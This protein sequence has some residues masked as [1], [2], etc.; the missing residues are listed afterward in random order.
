MAHF[1]TPLKDARGL[2][3]AKEGVEHWWVQRVTAVAL[4]PLMVWFV[5]SVIG[6][7][8]ADYLTFVAW[9]AQP[10]P[11][12][13][14]ILTIALT[15]WHGALGMQVVIEDYIHNEGARLAVILLTKFILYGLG[16]ATIFAVLRIAL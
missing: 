3:S 8:G 6:L 9:L 7:I 10:I 13:L 16:V 15:F 5:I 12:V 4:V 1:R 14:M 2:G 11:A